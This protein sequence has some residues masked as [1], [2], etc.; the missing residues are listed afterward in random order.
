MKIRSYAKI[1]LGLEILRKRE[2][3]YHE[4][5]TL[6]QSIDFYDVLELSNLHTE[7][8]LLK[9]N[10]PSVCWDKNNLIH[11]AVALLRE[12]CGL[13]RGVA[14]HVDKRIPPGR[15]LGG[16]SSNAA[17]TLYALN[18]MWELGLNKKEL[19]TLGQE[20]GADVP[21]FL[22]GGLC[23]G[24]ARGDIVTPLPDIK[25]LS[26]V[27]AW[28]PFPI[29]TASVYQ[30]FCFSLTSNSKESK[31]MKLLEQKQFGLLENDLE[32]TVFALYPQLR[33]IKSLF[34]SQGSE[35][36]L[37]SGAG[38]SVFGLFLDVERARQVS[39]KLGKDFSARIVQTLTRERYWKTLEVGV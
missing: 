34:Q 9:G 3:G 1:N 37:V 13:S 27:L 39:K 15:G 19:M 14:I 28:P 12:R 4:I 2:D 6:F 16:G 7:G 22:E 25:P 32:E 5:K 8:I 24:E 33:V 11:K 21:F 29:P 10:D 30:R 18:K 36:S 38:S 17:M 26:C 20:L 31:M 35:A 23:L